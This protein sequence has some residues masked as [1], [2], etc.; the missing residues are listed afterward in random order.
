MNKLNKL[1]LSVL[2]IVSISFQIDAATW[3]VDRGATGSNN[4]QSWAN[5]WNNTTSINWGSVT[6]GDTIYIAGGSYSSFT[7]TSSGT[8]NNYI[9]I[10]RSLE[11]GKDGIVTIATPVTL[12][13]NYLKFDG[14]GYKQVSGN[15]YRCGIVFTCSSATGTSIVP[16]G[17]AVVAS[18]NRPWFKYC[19]FNG[20]YGAG[21]G[22]SFGARNSTGFILERCWFFQSSF[23][24]Q[25]VYQASGA[26]GSVSI[27][28]T[29]FQH[30]QRPTSDGVHRDVANPWTGSG[31]WNL[32][33]V[34]NIIFNH[35]TAQQG[36]VFLLQIGYSGSATPLN[37][38]IAINNVVYQTARFIAFG[39]SN[40]GVNK[41]VL[42][43]NTV[44]NVVNGDNLGVT[45]RSYT[46]ANNIGNNTSNPGFVNATSPIGA[47]GIPFT[48]DDGFNIASSSSAVN[49]GSNI[50]VNFDILNNFRVGN[51]DLGAYES[52]S[53]SITNVPPVT[54]PPPTSQVVFGES[55]KASAGLLSG[56]FIVSGDFIYAPTA[57]SGR[58]EYLFKVNTTGD[59]LVSGIVNTPSLSENSF[60]VNVN[61]EPTEPN[62]IW[63][64]PVLS[65]QSKTV[66][67]RGTGAADSNIN[68]FK[69]F[70]LTAGVTNKLVILGRE[71]NARIG[72]INLILTNTV[73]VPPTP[74]CTNYV[75]NIVNVPFPV[76]ITNYMDRY[77]TNT[78]VVTNTVIVE[79]IPEIIST[80]STTD[81][82]NKEINVK[83]KY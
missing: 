20:N 45:G 30:N 52:G 63:D 42:Y 74:G 5:A 6:A 13:G 22:H 29:V 83:L 12:S 62:N 33:L 18:G 72:Q 16:S 36:D 9:T 8:A 46:S 28:N 25:W 69:L 65:N 56:G 75:T 47:D 38:V 73:V 71:A 82:N 68:G 60:V 67:W 64:I 3:Y 49:A 53:I 57:S 43:N 34:N 10:A 26:G 1:I 61:S 15:T 14:G 41:F 27:T 66:S 23:E 40:S 35:S 31:G 4:G 55:F 7:A 32:Y 48:A 78:V 37:E 50:G 79:V 59:Y 54:N 77:V 80:T 81:T 24:D 44:R 51:P 58:A 11:A 2:T 17:G 76:Y 39:S 21:T 70:S 19:Y